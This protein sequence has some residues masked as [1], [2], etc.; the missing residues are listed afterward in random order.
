[1]PKNVQVVIYIDFVKIVV[2]TKYACSNYDLY[3]S[4]YSSLITC[5]ITSVNMIKCI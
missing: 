2:W 4:A 5:T 1:M 3:K